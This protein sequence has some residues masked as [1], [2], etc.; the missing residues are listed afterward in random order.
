MVEVNA[1]L[2][3]LTN[4]YTRVW[5][6]AAPY[7]TFDEEVR[8]HAFACDTRASHAVRVTLYWQALARP[9]RAATVFV[10]LYDVAGNLIAQQD[11]EPVQGTYPTTE[12]ETENIVVDEYGLTIPHH[13]PAG[14]YFVAAGLYDSVT[15]ARWNV[16]AARG[17]VLPQ[18]RIRLCEVTR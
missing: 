6:H 15:H 11:N 12:W 10:H 8:L 14:T 3:R 18:N 1:D 4:K 17:D 13:A 7:S 2:Q 5:F 16:R 9:T